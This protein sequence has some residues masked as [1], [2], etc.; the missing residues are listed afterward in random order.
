MIY[1]KFGR[2][3]IGDKEATMNQVCT[4]FDGMGGLALCPTHNR[5]AAQIYTT[6]CPECEKHKEALKRARVMSGADFISDYVVDNYP[7]K[8]QEFL[9]A[10]LQGFMDADD[11]PYV[12][13]IKEL[14]AQIKKLARGEFICQKCGLRKD[15]ENE[16]GDF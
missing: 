8:K 4:C 16:H 6:P 5:S 11:N 13:R 10:A 9:E 3:R 1:G 12:A 2:W 14:E 7:A 15:G